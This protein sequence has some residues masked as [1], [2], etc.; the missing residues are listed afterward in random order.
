MNIDMK[1]RH[2][3]LDPYFTAEATFQELLMLG[4]EPIRWASLLALGNFQL[5][6]PVNAFLLGERQ[7]TMENA[8]GPS[9]LC[10]FLW[11]K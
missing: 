1:W 8:G 3:W 10:V 4:I 5:V 9:V 7:T 11:S 6:V 2:V